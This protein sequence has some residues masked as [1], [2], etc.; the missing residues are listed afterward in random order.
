MEKP[1]RGQIHIRVTIRK[2][3]VDS[4]IVHPKSIRAWRDIYFFLSERSAPY[5]TIL[6]RQRDFQG[7]GFGYSGIWCVA[8]RDPTSIRESGA[9]AADSA[10]TVEISR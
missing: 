9:E 6:V 3:P 7:F 4:R 8:R 1:R 2:T 10:E 5:H